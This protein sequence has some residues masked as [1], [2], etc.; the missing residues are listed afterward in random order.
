[1]KFTAANVRRLEL[2][3]GVQERIWFDASLPG[4]GIRIRQG[5]S[6]TWITQYAIAGRSRRMTLGSTDVLDFGRAKETARDVLAKVRLGQDPAREK[7]ESR[8]R[9]RETLA[10]F[11]QQYLQQKKQE[12]RPSS[13]EETDRYLSRYARPWHHRPVAQIDRRDAAVLITEI[14]GKHGAATANRARSA[15]SAFYEWAVKE[16]LADANPVS[17][18]NKQAEAGPRERSLPDAELVQVWR[19]AGDDQYGRIL[20]C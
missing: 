8:D 18:T 4:F 19:A 5:G 3:A 17:F 11:L 9:A 1:M 2:P 12:L 13:Y 15:L 10:A 7:V 20:K 14:A 6:R 16:G